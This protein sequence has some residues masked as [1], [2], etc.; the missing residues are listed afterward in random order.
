MKYAVGEIIVLDEVSLSC[1]NAQCM[2]AVWVLSRTIFSKELRATSRRSRIDHFDTK[3]STIHYPCWRQKM[4][5][6][7]QSLITISFETFSILVDVYHIY[8]GNCYNANEVF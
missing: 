6:K 4:T 8:D 3:S 2:D 7:K 1:I 5:R